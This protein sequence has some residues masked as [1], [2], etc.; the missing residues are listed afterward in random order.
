MNVNTQRKVAAAV[1]GLALG[2]LVLDKTL[3]SPKG[4]AAAPPGAGQAAP[5]VLAATGTAPAGPKPEAA[6]AAAPGKS[7]N[8]PGRVSSRLSIAL[9]SPKWTAE[10]VVGSLRPSP[11]WASGPAAAS[12][13]ASDRAGDFRARHELKAVMSGQGGRIALIDGR[14]MKEGDSLTGYTLIEV[15]ARSAVFESGSERIVLSLPTPDG[16]PAAPDR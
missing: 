15:R 9:D 14:A 16:A 10:Q 13:P 1:L 7:E 4:A 3:L 12:A 5:A 11:E 6:K 2:A 8:S